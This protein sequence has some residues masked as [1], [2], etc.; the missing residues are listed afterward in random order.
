MVDTNANPEGVSYV[1]PGNDDALRSIRL[2]VSRVAEAVS[3]G[4]ALRK[5]TK[6][7]AEIAGGDSVAKE[8]LKAAEESKKTPEPEKIKP[9]KEK[10]AEQ[11]A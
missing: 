3:E 5:D 9:E 8:I 1:L 11:K 6:A 7:A 2:F 10:A 4:V